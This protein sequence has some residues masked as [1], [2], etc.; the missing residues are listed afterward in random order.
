MH[1]VAISL[2]EELSLNIKATFAHTRKLLYDAVAEATLN[3]TN[4]VCIDKH[5]IPHYPLLE[6]VNSV[7]SSWP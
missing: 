4:A 1:K 6:L 7:H 3:S 2:I 5:S